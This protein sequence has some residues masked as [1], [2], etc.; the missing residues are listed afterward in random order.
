MTPIWRW[1]RRRVSESARDRAVVEAELSEARGELAR[2]WPTDKPNLSLNDA[3]S[4]DARAALQRVIRL[5]S[6][7]DA[8]EDVEGEAGA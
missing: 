4:P 6:E 2:M 3:P 7:L 8:L 5:Q 1:R